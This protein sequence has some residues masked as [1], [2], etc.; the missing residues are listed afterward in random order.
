MP[1]GVFG[2]D[3]VAHFTAYAAL[4]FTL[5]LWPKAETWQLHRL[6]T[7]I[8]IIAIASVYG[9]IDELHQSF[10]PGRDASVYDW[11]ADTLGVG[12]GMAVFAW[13]HSRYGGDRISI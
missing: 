7:G 12:F 3:K 8:I 13:W 11:I 2:L 5:A 10:V 4:A 6:R 9:G 1:E